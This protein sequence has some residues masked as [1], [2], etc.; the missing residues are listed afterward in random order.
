MAGPRADKLITE[1]FCHKCPNM[2]QS[3]K[4]MGVASSVKGISLAQLLCQTLVYD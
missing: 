3:G 1:E 4:T 2:E